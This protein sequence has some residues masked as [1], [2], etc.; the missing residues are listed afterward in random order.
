MVLNYLY[1]IFFLCGLNLVTAEG[2]TERAYVLF[3]SGD[4]RSA[5]KILENAADDELPVSR[6]SALGDIY[7][8]IGDFK[9]AKLN[10]ELAILHGRNP[11][12]KAGLQFNLGL[13]LQQSNDYANALIAFKEALALHP[14]LAEAHVKTAYLYNLMA[15]HDQVVY[16]LH[17][18]LELKPTDVYTYMYLADTLNNLKRWEEA[19]QTYRKALQLYDSSQARLPPATPLF[20]HLAD[21]LINMKRFK[22]AEEAYRSALTIHPQ[23]P[24]A[25]AGLLALKMESLD[26]TDWDVLVKGALKT[27]KHQVLNRQVST[28]SPYRTLFLPMDAKLR[29]SIAESWAT[30]SIK[31]SRT[32]NSYHTPYHLLYNTD[33]ENRKVAK[34]VL[35]V[36]YMSRRFESYPGTQL[37]LRIFGKQICV[38]IGLFIYFL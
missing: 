32:A 38:F 8:Q 22:E 5:V 18:A 25:T 2:E 26:W 7:G 23:N 36:G 3:D 28:L 9:K 20:V 31:S 1:L 34:E 16:H 27:A 13:V 11:K 35:R 4:A 14:G 21:T 6:Y 15:Q 30:V 33:P 37:M 19:V 17:Q 24:E 10:F 29:T 12:E